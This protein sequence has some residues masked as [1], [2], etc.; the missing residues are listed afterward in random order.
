MAEAERVQLSRPAVFAAITLMLVLTVALIWAYAYLLL[1]PGGAD[2][3]NPEIKQTAKVP[4]ILWCAGWP[5]VFTRRTVPTGAAIIWTLGCV[6]TWIHIA[7]AFHLGHGWSHKAA[8]E[9]TR[10]VGGYGDG[11]FVNYAFALVWLVDVLWAWATLAPY[12]KRPQWLNWTIHSFMAF[13][14]LNAAVVFGS[15]ELR[16][17][18]AT[19]FGS[20]L[21]FALFLERKKQAVTAT[22]IDKM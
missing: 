9:H 10:Q 21:L 16:I 14:V 17:Q 11:I 7:V 5:I 4:V 1:G 19:F 2:P 20:S 18:F 22:D 8:W 3:T 15:Q 6:L 12:G 13:V